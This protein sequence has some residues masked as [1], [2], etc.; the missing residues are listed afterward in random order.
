MDATLEHISKK[1]FQFLHRMDDEANTAYLKR[2]HAGLA[3]YSVHYKKYKENE[4]SW[5]ER[6]IELLR[7]DGI[8]ASTEKPYPNLSKRCDIIIEMDNKKLWLEVKSAWKYWCNSKTG[9][10]KKEP[11]YKGYL[12]GDRSRNNSS[13]QDIEKLSHLSKDDADY[14][15]LLI[16]GFDIADD[17][18]DIE[19]KQLAEMMKLEEDGWEIYDPE[20]WPDRNLPE[21]RHNCW[22][23][24]KKVSMKEQ[25][26]IY[27]AYCKNCKEDI[28]SSS[29]QDAAFMFAIE[30]CKEYNH[31]LVF[32]M[33]VHWIEEP[34]DRE[35]TEHVAYCKVCLKDIAKGTNKDDVLRS[36][37]EHCEETK[38]ELAYGIVVK[39]N[40]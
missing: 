38:H 35:T 34:K 18:I 19:M 2:H 23:M 30:H 1:L 11:N 10:K 3:S 9:K 7:D 5:S 16:V 20:V 31:E 37:M 21:C 36:A 25:K 39:D 4:R 14:I 17:P 27:S 8:S 29:D 32:G 28:S 22:F 6:I 12:F 26:L 24:G 40:G 33:A 13:A 15:G